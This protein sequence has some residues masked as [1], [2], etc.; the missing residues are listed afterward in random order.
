MVI[1]FLMSDEPPGVASG[2]AAEIVRRSLVHVS[3]A[4]AHNPANAPVVA[5]R[6]GR[7]RI[8]VVR[9]RWPPPG[10]GGRGPP[11]C[12]VVP[13]VATYPPMGARG[14]APQKIWVPSMPMRCTSTM[15]RT[16]DLAVAVP[17]PTGPPDAL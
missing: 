13:D 12:V 5:A 6:G 4:T 1:P 17:T 16:I 8:L 3:A 2:R 10:S 7:V 9:V 11:E 14:L 15:F